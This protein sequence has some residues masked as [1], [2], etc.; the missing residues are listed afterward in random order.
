MQ[1]WLQDFE[2]EPNFDRNVVVM[3]CRL[4]ERHVRG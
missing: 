1:F 4:S 2:M 3:S